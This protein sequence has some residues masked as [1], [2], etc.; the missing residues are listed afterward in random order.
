MPA[1]EIG[2][3]GRTS[4]LGQGLITEG[5]RAV[6]HW[7]FAALGARRIYAPVDE[8][9]AASRRLCE[10]IG[11]ELEGRLRHER[12]DPDG[13]LRNSCLYAAIR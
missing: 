10:R 5:A 2:W 12:A 1:L 9:N 8:E 4:H 7:G 13:Q 3:W 11:M 6:L